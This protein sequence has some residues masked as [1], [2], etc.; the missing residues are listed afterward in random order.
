MPLRL[1][2]ASDT[3]TSL[4]LCYSQNT[5]NRIILVLFRYRGS[6]RLRVCGRKRTRWT[7]GLSVVQW[8]QSSSITAA[9]DF[10][11]PVLRS[12]GVLHKS[13]IYDYWVKSIS[14]WTDD[15]LSKVTLRWLNIYHIGALYAWQ[16][17]FTLSFVVTLFYYTFFTL[18]CNFFSLDSQDQ[19]RHSGQLLGVHSTGLFA[20]YCPG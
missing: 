9:E 17:K 7:T 8:P 16:R 2:P 13:M 12:L 19:A 14:R 4:K 6:T 11:M 18:F 10:R 15:I 3:Y 20:K 1:V 5:K